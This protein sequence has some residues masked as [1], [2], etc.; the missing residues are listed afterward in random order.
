MK[1]ILL[2][3]VFVAVSVASLNAEK[4]SSEQTNQLFNDC[5]TNK[6]KNSCQKLIDNGLSSV[7]QCNEN[8]NEIGGIYR[9]AENYQQAFKYFHKACNVS[10]NMRGCVNLGIAYN[11]GEGVKQNFFEALKF[12][13][14]ACDLNNSMACNNLG[15]LYS[16]GQGVK[17]NHSTAKQYYGKACDLG[18]QVG[19]DNY[20]ILNEQGV[21]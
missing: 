6:N 18:E 10:G 3:V 12:Y 13:K 14:R 1:K 2:C 8:C 15:I 19:C 16:N 7:E 11:D 9:F 21:K 5:V 17:Q 20:K 4:L